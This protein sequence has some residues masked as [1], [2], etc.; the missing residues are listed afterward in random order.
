MSL[1]PLPW[2]YET[3]APGV[4][5]PK[6]DQEMAREIR[7]VFD[8]GALMRPQRTAGEMMVEPK[9][10]DEPLA[11]DHQIIWLQPLCCVDERAWC[12]N[13]PGPCEDCGMPSI[14]YVRAPSER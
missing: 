12:Q 3:N 4:K 9:K 13:D 14:K 7:K 5:G 10:K 6:S 2:N 1:P 11:E 8:Q